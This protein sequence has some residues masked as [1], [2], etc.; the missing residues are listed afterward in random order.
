MFLFFQLQNGEFPKWRPDVG[1]NRVLKRQQAGSS[2]Q[3]FQCFAIGKCIVRKGF[4]KAVQS[5]LDRIGSVR[6]SLQAG[7]YALR[8]SNGFLVDVI[9]QSADCDQAKS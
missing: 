3:L 5:F 4:L 8:L 1:R 7:N 2:G 9:N 6:G